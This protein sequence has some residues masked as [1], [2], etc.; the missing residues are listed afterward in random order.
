M[1]LM[2]HTPQFR[3][4]DVAT[5]TQ[6]LYGRTG[7]LTPLPSERDQNFLLKTADGE[8][9]VLKIANALEDR[10]LLEAQNDMLSHLAQSM[11]LCPQPIPTRTGQI[12]ADVPAPSG[13][14]HLVRLLTYLPG[15]PLS[16]LK[17]HSPK[18]WRH[19][20]CCLGQLDRALIDF[21]HPAVH[22]E[23]H[24]DLAQAFKVIDTYQSLIA[25]PQLRVLVADL[26]AV[27]KPQLT[28]LLPQLRQSVIQNDA[29]DYNVLVGGGDDLMGRYQHVVGLI[30][31]GDVVYSYTVAEA[32]I[33][34]AYAILDKPDPLVIITQI[35]HGYDREYPLRE[36][37]VAALFG[38]VCMR[39]C[40]SVCLAAHQQQQR[41]DDA[42]LRISQEPIC[43]ILPQLAAIHPRWAEAAI[44]HACGLPSIPTRT[45]VTHWLQRQTFAHILGAAWD[46]LDCVVFDLGVDSP[47]VGWPLPTEPEL[48][49]RLWSLLPENGVGIGQY[50][51]ARLL[52]TAPEF[53]TG[54]GLT[55]ER[56]TIHL[57]IDLF[58]EAE[59]AVYA[60]LAGTV[61]ALANNMLPQD[62]G[63][64][65]ILQHQTDDGHLF[66]T[67]YGHL[68]EASLTRWQPG[69]TV[70]AGEQIAT[71]GAPSVN[72]G[73]SPHLHFQIVLDLLAL[74]CDFPGV[75]RASE[76]DLWTAVSPDPNLILQIP[77]C[78]FP[79]AKPTKAE[80]LTAR[81]HYIGRNLSLGY[82]DHVKMVRGWQQYLF[83]ESGRRYLDA[84]NNV[85]HVGHCHPRVVAAGVAQMHQ[86]NTNTRYLHDAINQYAERLSATFP[87][88]LTVCFFVN[89]ASEGNE[90]AL[91]LARAY[92]RQRDI[93]VLEAAYHGHTTSLVDM[94]PYKHDGPGGEGAPDWVHTAPLADVY[95]GPYKRDDPQAG[96]KYAEA[97]RKIIE[98]LAQ[99]GRGLAGFIAESCPSVGGQ[100]IFP[101]G[102]LAQVY[103]HIRAAGGVCIADEVQTGYGRIGSHFYGFL[104]QGVVPD[105]VVLGKPIGNGHPIGAVVTTSAIAEAF[106]NGMEFFSTFGGNTVSCAIGLTVLDV[107]LEEN[108][109]AHAW[110]VGQHLLAGLRPFVEQ[111]D[112]VGDV[113]GS[114]LFLGMELVRDHNTLEPA[115]AEAAF[116]ANQMRA[117]GILLGIDG[118]Y[119]NVLKIR[120]PMPFTTS[121]ADFLVTTLDKIL[122]ADFG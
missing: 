31:F 56:R 112:I 17:R 50:Q 29:N 120:P 114:G 2:E 62:Y 47:L 11:T 74:D 108:L 36:S 96:A 68:S 104:E 102:Y 92:T 33:A 71:I 89:S 72:G 59:T 10:L 69:Q 66:Y 83:D 80:T 16:Q 13:V 97:V 121:D 35:V 15:K 113:R 34:A 55:D 78:H 119:H 12:I 6:T 82:N 26:T 88:P 28:P 110:H 24:W 61:Y 54:D 45:A 107:V 46:D 42:Y 21:D 118:P 94:S 73:W 49:Q 122:A 86:L 67:I 75:C 27:F 84:Y 77:S 37:E 18:L 32:A 25:D 115:T 22:R 20:G 43:R 98:N 87:D 48:S 116:I 57:G 64:I 70:A 106:D 52:Y 23:F 44:R 7:T 41:P 51:E 95:R 53:A 9:F 105:I 79:P 103:H 19:L 30:D 1:T 93:I 63:P 76:R 65:I 58:V 60:P 85:P 90:L 99:D 111:Y 8:A 39:L 81:R 4:E 14:T 5:L 3:V 117:H 100:I 40:V 101:P 91:R 38:L 109:Q